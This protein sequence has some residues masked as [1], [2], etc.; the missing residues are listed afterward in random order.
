MKKPLVSIIIPTFNR[1]EFVLSAVKS[2]LNQTYK[3]IEVIVVDDFST[4]DTFKVI[5]KLR[6]KKLK[7]FR[8]AKNSGGPFSRNKGLSL[9]KGE[10]INFLDDDDYLYPKKI[11]LQVKKFLS[12]SKKD[13]GVVTCDVKYERLDLSEVKK[14]RKK[15]RIYKDLLKSY[16]VFAT[17]SMLIK[18]VFLDDIGGFDLKLASNQE[19]DLAIKLSK[20]SDF[21]Y[22]PKVLCEVKE[23]KDQISFNFNKKIKGTKYLYE[24]YKN[25]YKKHGLFLFNYLRFSYLLFKYR[26]G[27][28][29][30]KKVYLLF[31]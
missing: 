25:E 16:C 4:D 20:Y 3:N 11:E 31:P 13:L 9:A 17:H 29:L 22:V 2:A 10:F 24:K 19:Y 14:N 8:N 28:Y 15:G 23:S 26:I 21:D 7:V 1:S 6:S 30:G 12:S 5:S 18:K 27:K